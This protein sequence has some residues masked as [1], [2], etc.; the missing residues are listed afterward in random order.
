MLSSV[1]IYIYI[2]IYTA[3]KENEEWNN[4]G[5]ACPAKCSDSAPQTCTEQCTAGCFCKSGFILNKE[6]GNCIPKN[7]CSTDTPITTQGIYL[8][9]FSLND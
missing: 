3:C 4:C 5:S 1:Y 7:E 2:R 8:L 9:I 6:N